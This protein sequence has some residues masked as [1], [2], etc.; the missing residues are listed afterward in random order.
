MRLRV[1]AVAVVALVAVAWRLV[2]AGAMYA[3]NLELVTAA[4][5]AATLLLP[6]SVSWTVPLVAVAGSDAL[7]GNTRIYL[8]T[9]SAWGVTALASYLLKRLRSRRSVFLGST[10]F[11]IAS[12]TWFFLWTNFGVWAMGAGTFYPTTWAGLLACYAAGVPFYRTMLVGNLLF[13]PLVAFGALAV[14]ERHRLTLNRP[15]FDEP[16]ASA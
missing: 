5:V 15:A 14:R 8:F 12:S 13:V 9:W 2:N 7:I 16:S 3:P 1:F 4:T 11:G 10:V 6:S